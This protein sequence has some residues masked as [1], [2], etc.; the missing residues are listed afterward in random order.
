MQDADTILVLAPV[1]SI[2]EEI[3]VSVEGLEHGTQITAGE[4]ALFDTNHRMNQ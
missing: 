3:E 1:L 4:I 2:P